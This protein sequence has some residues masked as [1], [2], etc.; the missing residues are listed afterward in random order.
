MSD[1][2]AEYIAP[3]WPVLVAEADIGSGPEKVT[4]EAGEAE[5]RAL[6]QRFDVDSIE[7]LRA[8]V[9]VNRESGGAVVHVSGRFHA[10]LT[11]SCVV[12][13]DPVPETIEEDFEGWFSDP[14]AAISLTKAR[15]LKE[16]E[17]GGEA[18][19]LEER[20]DPEPIIDGQIDIGELVAQHVSLAINPYPHAP[21]V[22]YEL[23]DDS[24]EPAAEKAAKNP[25]AKL[26]DWK[27]RQGD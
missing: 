6:A 13:G 21:D 26:K 3:E 4:I 19:I 24:P 17:K 5:R 22:H 2:K 14:D 25:F 7:A 16:R 15:Y 9:T 27:E 1:Q 8:D 11:Q 10:E 12:S 18:P 23:G 20:D